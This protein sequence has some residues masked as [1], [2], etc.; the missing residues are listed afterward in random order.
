MLL[1]PADGV[2]Y[3]LLERNSRPQAQ[4]ALDLAAI[5][6]ITPVVPRPILNVADQ[7]SRLAHDV[8]QCL[9]QSEVGALTAAAD[10]VNFAG[11]P[12]PPHAIDRGT[13]I[14]DMNPV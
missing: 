14:A 12:L 7:R 10:V 3:S 4:L 8:E 11:P 1:I 13:M 9:C 6:C 5:N 2:A